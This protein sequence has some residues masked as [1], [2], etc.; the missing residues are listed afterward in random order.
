MRLLLNTCLYK[1]AEHPIRTPS[2]CGISI[3]YLPVEFEPLTVAY[4]AYL[5]IGGDRHKPVPIN[6]LVGI[7]GLEPPTF[8]LSVE[9]SNQ[10]GYT[11]I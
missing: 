3:V 5:F 10:L 6:L 7:G 8:R 11:P 4:Y 9:R 2:L 1:Y